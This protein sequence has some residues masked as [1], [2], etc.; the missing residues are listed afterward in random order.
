MFK[1]KSTKKGFFIKGIYANLIN[2]CY[3]THIFLFS[4]LNIY[5]YK[6]QMQNFYN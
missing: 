6:N 5:I 2:I 4:K 1:I 3:L